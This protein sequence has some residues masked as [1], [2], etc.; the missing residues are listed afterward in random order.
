VRELLALP[1]SVR[2]L[3]RRRPPTHRDAPPELA[4]AI[5]SEEGRATFA[6]E[7]RISEK[8]IDDAVRAGLD[9]AIDDAARLDLISSLEAGLLRRALGAFPVP[10]LMDALRSSAG[11]SVI[12]LLGELLSR[13]GG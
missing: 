6:T 11:K 2:S 13:Q 5:A 4:L 3:R 10:V 1:R 12:G 8:A 7:H 9:Q